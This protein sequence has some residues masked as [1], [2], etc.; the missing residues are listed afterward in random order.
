MAVA[1]RTGSRMDRV[2]HPLTWII[3]IVLGLV[4]G[5]AIGAFQERSLRISAFRRSS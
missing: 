1:Q 3:V 5:S 4:L 2:D